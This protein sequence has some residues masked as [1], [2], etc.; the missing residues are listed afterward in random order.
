MI[1]ER[2][3]KQLIKQILDIFVNLH[4]KIQTFAQF[5]SMSQNQ[6]ILIEVRFVFPV[7]IVKTFI[8]SIP[9]GRE[10]IEISAKFDISAETYLTSKMVLFAKIVNDLFSQKAPFLMFDR[11]LSTPSFLNA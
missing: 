4:R 10:N 7:S 1:A 2:K 5:I 6:S 3:L 8:C 11:F 9:S